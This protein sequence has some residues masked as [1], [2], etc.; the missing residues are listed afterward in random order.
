MAILF[1]TGFDYYDTD[2]VQRV[3]PYYSNGSSLLSGRFGGR[4]W[5]WNNEAGFLAAPVT[6][7][8]TI[9]MGMAFS[10]AYGDATNPIIVFQDATTSTSS[11]I[12]QI[13][14]RITNDAAI[15][16]TRNGSVL[17]TSLPNLF[18]FGFWN[19]IEVKVFINDSTGLV[20]VRLNGQTYLNV[21][22]VDT[23]Y[24]G[25]NYVNMI[26]IQPFAS[27][28]SYNF[29]IDDLYV[30]NDTGAMNNTFLGECRVQTQ[31][32]TADGD[33]NDF[34][35]TGASTNWEAV[36]ENPADD[37]TSFIS[38]AVV[39]DADNFEMGTVALTGA[40]YGVQINVMH[41][42]DDVGTRTITPILKSGTTTYE[43]ALISCQSEYT[44]AQKIWEQDPDT[45]ANWT[46]TLLNNIKAG[47]KIKG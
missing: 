34:A 21:A 41:R 29:K 32:P 9:I 40:V 12:T 33:Q 36:S 4:G 15:Q 14:V 38:S 1:F 25:N 17:G 31:F 13:D 22:A 18:L 24:T 39:G 37:D 45:T 30:L 27:S 28:G 7:S 20:Q 10:M 5:V 47:V 19:Y 42:K 43:G 16:V 44:V 3:W 6:A 35:I 46:N 8:S 23:K 11:P 2:Q 26:R